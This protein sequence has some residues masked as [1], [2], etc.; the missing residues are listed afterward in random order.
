MDAPRQSSSIPQYQNNEFNW[1]PAGKLV[2][3]GGAVRFM[4]NFLW[5]T[6]YE[7]LRGMRELVEQEDEVVEA[8]PHDW[9]PGASMPDY[10]EYLL[11]G[12]DAAYD[13]PGDLYP[14]AGQIFRLW[15]TFLDRVNSLT[16]IIHAPTLQP[17]VVEAA[18]SRGTLPHNAEALLFAVYSLSVITMTEEEC[19]TMLGSTCKTAFWRFSSGVRTSLFRAEFL[20]S[21]DLT[22]LQA[23]V[24]HIVR[25]NRTKPPFNCIIC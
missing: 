25:L 5:A 22:T 6:V 8:G 2:V 20:K 11:V 7:E 10:S 17:L 19:M 1:K 13:D 16:K 18:S 23:L 14:R 24:L 15:Q 4:D 3:E 21:H 9:D 12:G